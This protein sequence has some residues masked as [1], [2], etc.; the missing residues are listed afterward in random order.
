MH[1][2]REVNFRL[3]ESG[4]DWAVEASETIKK[5]ILTG[6]HASLCDYQKLGKSVARAVPTP[7]H[8]F[9]LLYTLGMKTKN[10]NVTLFND[11]ALY[12]S[13]TMTSVRVSS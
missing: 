5:K 1:N 9:P 4:F 2:L 13:L 3:P 12:G 10:D 6:D 8:Y 11:A 7:D